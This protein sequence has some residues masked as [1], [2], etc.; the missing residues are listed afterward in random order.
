MLASFT[1]RIFFLQKQTLL[2]VNRKLGN[3]SVNKYIDISIIST[4]GC[5]TK[6][7]LMYKLHY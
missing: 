6:L 5:N 7:V 2:I 4:N 1:D 3:N